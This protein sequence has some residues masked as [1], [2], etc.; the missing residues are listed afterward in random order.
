VIPTA[1]ALNVSTEELFS[2]IAALTANAIQTPQAMTGL[3]AAL[4]NIQ[5]PSATAVKLLER[6]NPKF[7][8]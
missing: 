7:P 8:A 6:L 2:S 3:K 5:K 1:A 4:S